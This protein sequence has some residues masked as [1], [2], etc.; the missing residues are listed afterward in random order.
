MCHAFSRDMIYWDTTSIS[1][2]MTSLY[3]YDDEISSLPEIDF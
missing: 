1:E 2:D 3:T